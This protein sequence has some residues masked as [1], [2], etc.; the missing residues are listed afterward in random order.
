[1]IL[2]DNVGSPQIR[3]CAVPLHSELTCWII[4]DGKAGDEMQCIAVAEALGCRYELRRVHPRAPFTWFMPKGPIDPR[5]AP[6]RP[7][8]PIAPPFPDLAIG[9]GRRAIAYLRKVKA[10]SNGRT[11]TVC[12]KDPR[13]GTQ[14][15]DLI[16]VPEHDRLRGP[17]VL[18]S[19]TA[20]HR[21]PKERLDALRFAPHPLIDDLPAPR[22]AVLVGGDSRHHR[23]T[24]TDCTRLERGLRDWAAHSAAHLMITTSRRTPGLLAN[25][26]RSLA[27]EGGHVMWN[28]KGEN[29]LASYLAKADAIVVTA[30]S[31]NMIG[32]AAGTGV[33]VH[34]FHPSG[35]HAKIS[36]FLGTLDRLGIIHPFPG[37]MKTTTYE[38]L[39]PTGD[40]AKAI[41]TA[42]AV[43]IRQRDEQEQGTAL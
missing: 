19:P 43:P 30:D 41:L 28:G 2:K 24:E 3:A 15:A 31:T 6:S 29:P 7:G 14:A 8:S 39:D 9:S 18:V 10:A 17:N 37:P 38:A 40:I 11:F 34:V 20:P 13:T 5:E 23:F 1:M 25:H 32:E 36:R 26:L 33:P 35:G 27:R 42:M 12:L 21:F 22:V 16:W 4:T